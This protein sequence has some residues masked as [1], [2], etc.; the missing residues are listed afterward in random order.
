MDE[1]DYEFYSVFHCKKCGRKNKHSEKLPIIERRGF[2]VE[3][4]TCELCNHKSEY[5]IPVGTFTQTT[6]FTGLSDLRPP[7]RDMANYQAELKI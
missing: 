3:I 7:T 2:F 4:G 1:S 5:L 6:L